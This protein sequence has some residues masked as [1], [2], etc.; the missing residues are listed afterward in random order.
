MRNSF[1]LF[2]MLAATAG[3]AQTMYKCVDAQ[4]RVTY[5]NIPCEKQD[6]KDAGPVVDRSTTMPF[7]PAQKPAPR[8]EPGKAPAEQNK[9]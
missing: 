8:A 5:S 1:V 3:T 7:V 6:L 4:Q 9:K 2:L